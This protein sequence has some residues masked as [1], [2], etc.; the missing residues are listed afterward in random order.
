MSVDLAATSVAS[1][2]EAIRRTV[3]IV[4]HRE[5]IRRV[6][7]AL[8]E[9]EGFH[10][11]TANDADSIIPL[12]LEITPD[13]VTLDVA[14]LDSIGAAVLRALKAHPILRQIPVV[15]LVGSRATRDLAGQLGAA[16]LLSTPVDLDELLARVKAIAA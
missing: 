11:V 7:G 9:G 16:A 15:A 10:S 8:L 14:R 4:D 5:S 13:L 6:L 1:R 2:P 12:A 3:L